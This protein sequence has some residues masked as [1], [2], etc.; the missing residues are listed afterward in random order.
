[1]TPE[2][3]LIEYAELR[4]K[5]AREQENLWNLAISLR[6]ADEAIVRGKRAYL[7]SRDLLEKLESLE[8]QVRSDV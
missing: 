3:T 8:L 5:I 1:M 6:H 7:E 2:Q 4:L